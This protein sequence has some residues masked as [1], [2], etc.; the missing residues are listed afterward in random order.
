MANL[1][2][3]TINGTTYDIKDAMARGAV[4]DI[5]TKTFTFTISFDAGT[6]GTRGYQGNQDILEGMDGYTPVA[7]SIGYIG[8][9]GSYLPVAFFNDN[10]TKVYLNAYRVTTSAVSNSNVWVDVI[11]IG[12]TAVNRLYSG[13]AAPAASLGEDGDLYLQE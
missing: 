3:L 6:I 9:S 11:Y 4:A 13:S 1:S 5:V 10:K 2:K 7:T 12:E 8:A